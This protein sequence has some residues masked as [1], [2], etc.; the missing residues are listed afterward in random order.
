MIGES[1]NPPL[2][3]RDVVSRVKAELSSLAIVTREDRLP[4]KALQGIFE[5]VKEYTAFGIA[6]GKC[7]KVAVNEYEYIAGCV[8]EVQKVGLM[9]V[10]MEFP[11]LQLATVGLTNDEKERCRAIHAEARRQFEGFRSDF[12]E[13]FD[14]LKIELERATCESSDFK[15]V[16]FGRTQVGKSTVRE[17]LTCGDGSTIG[18][19]SSSTTKVCH[20]YVWRNLHVWDTPGIDSRKDTNHDEDGVGDEE[21]LANEKLATADL[22]V[23]I[24]KTDTLETRERR[25]LAR[26]VRS[27]RPFL[28][29]L[30]VVA[31]FTDYG[32]FMRRHKDRSINR[33]AQR[34]FIDDLFHPPFKSPFENA[35]E[36]SPFS[37]EEIRLMEKRLITIHALA[38]FY[39]RAK[40]SNEVEAFYQ[41]YDVSR[42]ELYA[43]SN[44]GEF[45][46]YLTRFIC[47]NGSIERR[48]TID[49]V[50]VEKV[51]SF[52][53]R[54]R[55]RICS[56]IADK[57]DNEIEI[58]RRG[59]TSLGTKIGNW[60][61]RMLAG[62]IAALMSVEVDTYR[63]ASH[64]IE[65]GYGKDKIKQYWTECLNGT[66][67]APGAMS[68]IQKQIGEEFQCDLERTFENMRDALIMNDDAFSRISKIEDDGFDW[69]NAAKW[70]GRL[71][72]WAAA[73]LFVAANWWNPAGWVG[74]A[75][76]ACAGLSIVF[77]W[78]KGWFSSKD[79]KI[80]KLQ[81]NFD[82]H[83]SKVC[84]EFCSR[85]GQHFAS[86]I[87]KVDSG[88]ASTIEMHETLKGQLDRI[89]D[90]CQRAE[91]I[92]ASVESRMRTHGTAV[93]NNKE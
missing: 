89:V 60:T 78:V 26:I 55:R 21:R 43:L 39:S 76:W 69:R 37:D 81:D 66:A 30:N 28:I 40:N 48:R 47:E 50:F 67:Q 34:E 83:L 29:L 72:G 56:F 52:F 5:S 58:F 65:S 75:A 46:R 23:F 3:F 17:A 42:T 33:N 57:I 74:I 6:L 63:I 80:R 90:V 12:G 19:G 9:V 14:K 73:G 2:P 49:R 71:T 22:A 85:A 61:G 18:R 51:R 35:I 20:E 13:E 54:A 92:V 79:T 59:R 68:R 41:K 38:C 53:T 7:R 4:Y 15:V 64:C 24:C 91:D 84:D 62:R 77:T 70:G 44:F 10:D 8:Q 88:L 16:L 86:V 36:E 25:N 31:S 1:K 93:K 87:R 11:P 27:G 82:E 32:N 45:R